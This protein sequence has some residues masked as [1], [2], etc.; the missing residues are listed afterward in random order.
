MLKFL[1]K[2]RIMG[3]IAAGQRKGDDKGMLV[4]LT[5]LW[6]KTTHQ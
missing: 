4:A 3:E 2:E 1:A 6:A 5:G